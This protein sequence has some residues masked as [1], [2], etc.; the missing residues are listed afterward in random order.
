[1]A[2]DGWLY[3]AYDCALSIKEEG[4]KEICLK[5]GVVLAYPG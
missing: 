4:K 1:M 2:E 5:P 3:R